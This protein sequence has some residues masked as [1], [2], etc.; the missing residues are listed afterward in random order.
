MRNQPAFILA[1]VVTIGL[2][3]SQDAHATTYRDLCSAVP[4][5]CEF[6]G[7][8]APVLV[9][10]VCWSMSTSTATLMT[11]ATCPTGSWAY[12][13]KY[14]VVDPFSL[15]V[16]AFVPLDDAC[17]RPG[18]CQP[19]SF[20]PPNT[21]L[22]GVICCFG[23]ICYPAGGDQCYGGALFFCSDGVSNDDGTV[24]CFEHS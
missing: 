19:G 17:S 11:G 5:A 6:T 22:A 20:A 16:A 4:G 15:I 13:V 1:V 8:D 18:L 14:G 3:S 7:P 23:D 10:N 9:A 24:T 21:V 12:S 2:V